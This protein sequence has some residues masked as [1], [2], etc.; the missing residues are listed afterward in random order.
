MDYTK[1]LN[2][3]RNVS[4][5]PEFNPIVE[6]CKNWLNDVRDETKYET[7]N[8]EILESFM[9]T[10]WIE[11]GWVEQFTCKWIVKY[12]FMENTEKA[13]CWKDCISKYLENEKL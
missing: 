3:T 9:D 5:I 11:L 7:P 4:N 10:C 12:D 6:M 1:I 8:A 2:E 13:Q